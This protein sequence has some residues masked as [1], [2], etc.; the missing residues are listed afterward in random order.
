MKRDDRAFKI[1]LF[2]S[3][4]VHLAALLVFSVVVVLD[5][6]TVT[7]FVEFTYV[8]RSGPDTFTNGEVPRAGEMRSA[9]LIN[10]PDRAYA[11]ESV[12]SMSEK[13]VSLPVL[14][15]K[16]DMVRNYTRVP[17]HIRLS[18]PSPV[19]EIK[20]P[21]GLVVQ[22]RFAEQEEIEKKRITIKPPTL[23][24]PDWAVTSSGETDG[25]VR[26]TV[27]PSSV[28]GDVESVQS[29]GS[30]RVGLKPSRYIRGWRV[31]SDADDG[32]GTI[33]IKFRLK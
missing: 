27:N 28:I 1:T 24:Y 11:E 19:E 6:G 12:V 20:K 30:A 14:A 25:K 9:P 7:P 17:E 23:D 3:F 21:I 22:Q 8:G 18:I 26:M 4:W 2:V 16:V 31:D 13:E 33:S 32:D 29:D 10:L 15:E 5:L